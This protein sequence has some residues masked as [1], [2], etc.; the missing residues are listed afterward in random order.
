MKRENRGDNSEVALAKHTSHLCTDSCGTK[1]VS[2][3]V[4]R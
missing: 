4:Q 1:L 2:D 3:G